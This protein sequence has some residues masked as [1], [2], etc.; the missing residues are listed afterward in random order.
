MRCRNCSVTSVG[1]VAENA[2]PILVR[3]CH[4]LEHCSEEF[5]KL[6]VSVLVGEDVGRLRSFVN[7][8]KT[9]IGGNDFIDVFSD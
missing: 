3:R 8:A 2:F 7:D 9:A 6:E 5:A 4:Q 1:R